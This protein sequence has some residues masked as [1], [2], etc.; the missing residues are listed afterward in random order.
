MIPCSIKN[1]K[2]N[3]F[4]RV[5]RTFATSFG[6]GQY[7]KTIV[8]QHERVQSRYALGALSEVGNL[9][10]QI[11]AQLPNSIINKTAA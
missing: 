11:L 6:Y 9:A 7:N 4:L 5:L 8:G 3:I 2:T 1:I 10:H